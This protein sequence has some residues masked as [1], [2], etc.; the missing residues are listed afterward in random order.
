MSDDGRNLL[1][2][3]EGSRNH[4]G[5]PVL[6]YYDN[7]GSNT[8]TVGW[9]HVVGKAGAGCG[10]L[11]GKSITREE[12]EALFEADLK[13]REK[14]VNNKFK[15]IP[16]SQNQFDALV[17]LQ[18]NYEAY[19]KLAQAISY[20]KNPWIKDSRREELRKTIIKEWSNIGGAKGLK[21]R[22]AN[23][24]QLFF[25]GD[26]NRDENLKKYP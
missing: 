11:K 4:D 17:I 13:I 12:A 9:G 6:E 16:L 21:S 20:S 7:E 15:Y 10:S 23:E 2:N 24:L 3:Y 1:K 18:F 14:A 5:E 22:R 25:D 8:C 19:P 26:Y